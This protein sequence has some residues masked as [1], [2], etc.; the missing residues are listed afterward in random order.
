[1]AHHALNAAHWNVLGA[2]AKDHFHGAR[3]NGIIF[4]GARAMRADVMN[5]RATVRTNGGGINLGLLQSGVDSGRGA[6]TFGLNVRDAK[7]VG[8]GSVTNHFRK[9]R[10]ATRQCVLKF[11]QDHHAAAL[12]HDKAVAAHAEWTAC[13]CWITFES[14]QRGEAIETRHAQRMNHGV[15]STRHHDVGVAAADHA[16]GF[17]NG[18]RAGGARG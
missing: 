7:C 5:E 9:R 8:A 10:G 13:Q 16:E 12:A 1:M 3:F 4:L 6:A 15:R 11:F 17:A 18:L 14:A 2:L